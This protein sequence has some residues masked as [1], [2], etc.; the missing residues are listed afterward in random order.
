MKTSHFS[1]RSQKASAFTLIE[2]LVVIAIIAILAAILFPVFA[3][4]R[5]SA[6][7]SSCSSNLKQI[8]LAA[9]Q[10]S[11]DYDEKWMPWEDAYRFPGG[12]PSSW[13][14]TLQ[15]YMKSTQVITCP[16]DSS[17]GLFDLTASGF[18]RLRRS[19]AMATYALETTVKP[20]GDRVIAVKD[21]G[22]NG[23]ASISVFPATALTVLMGERHMCPGND[24]QEEY[25][26]C[27]TFNNTDQQWS[28]A[29]TVLWNSPAGSSFLH[30]GTINMLYMD[31]HVKAYVGTKGSLR[32]LDGH[33]YGNE[34][35]GGGGTWM[36]YNKAQNGVGD[37]PQ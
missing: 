9:I 2:L 19:Y 8:G 12:A 10:Y 33:P 27:S 22:T 24:S 3:R 31:G 6:R 35:G 30:L 18:G 36:T 26:G 37:Q 17:G 20:N 14:L 15:P 13:D 34:G 32:R 29:N 5:E 4:A 1:T 25:R 7:R 16:S 28:N 23:G 11:Q 21:G